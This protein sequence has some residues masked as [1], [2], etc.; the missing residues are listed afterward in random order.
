[1]KSVHL[2]TVRRRA[3]GRKVMDTLVGYV[4]IDLVEERMF[5]LSTILRYVAVAFPVLLYYFQSGFLHLGRDQF[6][7]MLIGTSLTAGLQDALTGLTSR[8]QFAQERGTLETYLVEPVP[9]AL[10][11]VAMNVWRSFTGAVLACLMMI[12]GWLLGAPIDPKGIPLALVVLFLGITACNAVGTLAASFLVLF[13]RGEPIIMLYGLAAAVL[14]G[15]LFPTSVLPGSI[16]WLSYLV[17]HSYVISAERQLL[18]TTPPTGSLSPLTSMAILAVF[19]LVAFSFG[20][21][22][23]DRSLNLARRLGILSV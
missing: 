17:P 6:A 20:L 14:G 12:C 15:A 1:M 10:I 16:R 7:F 19:C 8:L 23:F 18:M 2:T 3:F 21:F 5:P 22:L 13:K 9:W 11:P 4:R